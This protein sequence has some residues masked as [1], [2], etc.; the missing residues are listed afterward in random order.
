MPLTKSRLG[1]G[2]LLLPAIRPLK[3]IENSRGGYGNFCWESEFWLRVE[4]N[5]LRVEGKMLRVEIMP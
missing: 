1:C 2:L 5:M 3:E 4:G